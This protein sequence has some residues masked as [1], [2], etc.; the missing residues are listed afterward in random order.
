[1]KAGRVAR[2]FRLLR[3]LRLYGMYTQYVR[4]RRIKQAL[5]AAGAAGAAS[6]EEQLS[7]IEFE[8]QQ[9]EERKTKVG[10]KL[11]EL[12]TRRVI[13]GLLITILLLP[14]FDTRLGTFGRAR[15][16]GEGGLRM[17][18]VMA[19]NQGQ[20]TSAFA[21]ALQVFKEEVLF[22]AGTRTTGH[23]YSLM[24]ANVTHLAR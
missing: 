9:E 15:T 4:R 12:T 2:I 21:T 10:Q 3:M 1:S 22:G 23:L 19:V 13:V 16:V 7:M 8:M 6:S 18:H 14:S 5:Q 24:V 17:L 11:E 20:N